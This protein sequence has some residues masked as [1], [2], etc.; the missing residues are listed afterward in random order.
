MSQ[1]WIKRLVEV[2]WIDSASTN[3]WQRR[4]EIDQEQKQDGGLVEC[5]TVGYLL[6]KDKRSLRLAQSQSS[7]GAVAEIC[8]IPRSCIRSIREV[9]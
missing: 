3:G 5:R 1:A 2:E 8:A 7:H 9:R 4:G 6:S